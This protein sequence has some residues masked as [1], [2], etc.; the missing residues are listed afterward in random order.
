MRDFLIRRLV[1][2]IP[3]FFGITV[4]NFLLVNLMPGDA[5][6]AM[7]DPRDRQALTAEQL[8]ARRESL[9]LDKSL[10]ERYVIWVSELAHGN[11]GFSFVT[12]KPVLGELTNRLLATLKLQIVAFLVAVVVGLLLG[13]Y[14]ALH[15][16]SVFDY[17]AT[18]VSY[19]LTSVPVFFVA[20]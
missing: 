18:F 10:P 1:I 16:Y 14:A 9:G 17:S 8:A 5:V 15:Q 20:L 7:I 3:V 2:L 11:L 13:V 12:Q 6:D 4:I 19:I